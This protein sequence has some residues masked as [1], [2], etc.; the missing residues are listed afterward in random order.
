MKITDI[1]P[2]KIQDAFLTKP[3]YCQFA[4]MCVI[5]VMAT[6]FKILSIVHK[7][8]QDIC[9]KKAIIEAMPAEH[10]DQ[11]CELCNLN[12]DDQAL[13]KAMQDLEDNYKFKIK[14]TK[15]EVL[16]LRK[17]CNILQE[18]IQ[19]KLDTFSQAKTL[20]FNFTERGYHNIPAF[21][22][23]N[24]VLYIRYRKAQFPDLNDHYHVLYTPITIIEN[25]ERAIKILDEQ[26]AFE[27]NLIE[28]MRGNINH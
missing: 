8:T 15:E 13:A 28:R 24:G 6:A 4:V 2:F 23:D 27:R 7:K 22:D 20:K 25:A 9:A 21:Q 5:T 11:E 3:V 12:T 1:I 17:G 26:E 18:S 19:K 14:Q 10:I 16:N